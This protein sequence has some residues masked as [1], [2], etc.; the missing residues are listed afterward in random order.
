[1]IEVDQAWIEGADIRYLR[2]DTIYSV[3]RALVGASRRRAAARVS[4][5]PTCA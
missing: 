1:M 4:R 3:P 2:K 5:T